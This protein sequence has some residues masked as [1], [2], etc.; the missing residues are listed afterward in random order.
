MLVLLR[1]SSPPA[2]RQLKSAHTIESSPPRSTLKLSTSEEPITTRI[3]RKAATHLNDLR[4][5]EQPPSV[6]AAESCLLD[7]DVA[8]PEPNDFVGL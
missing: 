6:A 7:N 4:S 1:K 5:E 2:S 3:R 8:Q